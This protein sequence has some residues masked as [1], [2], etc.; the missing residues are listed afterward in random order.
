MKNPFKLIALDIKNKFSRNVRIYIYISSIIIFI[1]TVLGFS[2]LVYY[3]GGPEII[4][5]VYVVT[6]HGYIVRESIT[7]IEYDILSFSEAQTFTGMYTLLYL[8]LIIYFRNTMKAK[9]PQRR[10]YEFD[11][12]T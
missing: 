6:N 11:L 10:F 7:K 1:T 9:K 2:L 12:I 5:G 8:N 4:D 3:Q